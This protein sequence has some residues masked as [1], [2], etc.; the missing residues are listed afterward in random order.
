MCVS[1]CVSLFIAGA[2]VA[3]RSVKSIHFTTTQFYHFLLGIAISSSILA[4]QNL[5]SGTGPQWTSSKVY[6]KIFLASLAD[7]V[8]SV[9]CILAFSY[10][11]SGFVALMGYIIVFYGFLVDEFIYQ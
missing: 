11:S 9:S 2:G 1:L 5:M 6:W 7:Y 3:T 8:G 4:V 10:D